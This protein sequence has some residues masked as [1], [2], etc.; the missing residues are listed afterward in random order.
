MPSIEKPRFPANRRVVSLVYGGLR[1]FEFGITAEVF[2]LHRPEAESDWH[3]FQ[4]VSLEDRILHASGGLA[5]AATATLADLHPAGT[6]SPTID[7][8][9]QSAMSPPTKKANRGSRAAPRRL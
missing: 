2:S 6:M 9:R 5:V 8:K 1:T 3:T 7:H 4:S